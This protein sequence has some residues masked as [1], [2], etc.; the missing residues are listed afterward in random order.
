MSFG[1][2]FLV[3]LCARLTWELIKWVSRNLY[4]WI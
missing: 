4:R 2:T 1:S 3:V